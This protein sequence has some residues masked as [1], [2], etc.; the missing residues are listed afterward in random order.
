MSFA[1]EENVKN[2]CMTSVWVD[3]C[4]KGWENTCKLEIDK[5]FGLDLGSHIIKRSVFEIL[6]DI[7]YLRVERLK[8]HKSDDHDIAGK[9]HKTNISE[10]W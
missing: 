1:Y 5:I 9:S 3:R 6:V 7:A 4:W 8:S 10:W 2:I